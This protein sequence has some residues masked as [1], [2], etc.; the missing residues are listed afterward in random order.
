MLRSVRKFLYE[1]L[2]L[3]EELAYVVQLRLIQV[4]KLNRFSVD[5]V[6]DIFHVDQPSAWP[7]LLFWIFLR[8]AGDR[9]TLSEGLTP[10]VTTPWLVE[11]IAALAEFWVE[12]SFL[13]NGLESLL[14]LLFDLVFPQNPSIG[15]ILDM[16]KK[17][18]R[19]KLPSNQLSR[20]FELVEETA[21]DARKLKN[22]EDLSWLKLWDKSDLTNDC[23]GQLYKD[24]KL[25]ND[26]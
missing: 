5:F 7:Q 8:R 17:F 20:A 4:R 10:T 22:F 19:S 26:S 9:V 25:I 12:V 18:L 24:F 14:F 3:G 2:Q 11:T 21:A 6:F 15:R 16:V 13:T 1:K 23:A